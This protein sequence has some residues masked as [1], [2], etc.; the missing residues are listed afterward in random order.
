V[1][2]PVTGPSP[3][4][5]EGCPCQ[6]P[7]TRELPL[8]CSRHISPPA[9]LPLCYSRQQQHT[10]HNQYPRTGSTQ[11]SVLSGGCTPTPP[12]MWACYVSSCA[13]SSLQTMYCWL[14]HCCYNV[15]TLLSHSCYTVITL[16][17][18]CF[19]AVATLLSHCSYTVATL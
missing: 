7:G 14:L 15:V 8:C 5:I 6:L 10:D 11:S 2:S 12:C 4:S 16:L 9:V 19:H 17:L 13:C 3:E 1:A 18:Q